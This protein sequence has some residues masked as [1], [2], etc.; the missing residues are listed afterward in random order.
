MA[1]WAVG[2]THQIML[3]QRPPKKGTFFWKTK[4]WANFIGRLSIT[5]AVQLDLFVNL[6]IVDFFIEVV[7]KQSVFV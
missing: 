1:E 7:N 3:T 6:G 5:F 4:R 2:K